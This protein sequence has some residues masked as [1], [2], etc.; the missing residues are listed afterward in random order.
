ML[1]PDVFASNFILLIFTKICLYCAVLDK[2]G[3]K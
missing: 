3:Q 1:L 2:T